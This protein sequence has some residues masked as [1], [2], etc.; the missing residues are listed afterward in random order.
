MLGPLTFGN[1]HS[2]IRKR[3]KGLKYRPVVRLWHFVLRRAA[4]LASSFKYGLKWVLSQ[5][6]P[7]FV[8]LDSWFFTTS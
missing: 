1:S 5:L 3:T 4:D 8:D 7:H 6:G 2:G